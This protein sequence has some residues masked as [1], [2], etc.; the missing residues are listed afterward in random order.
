MT[1]VQMDSILQA[2]AQGGTNWAL[3]NDQ[4]NSQS[5][6]LTAAGRCVVGSSTTLLNFTGSLPQGGSLLGIAI[7]LWFQAGFL[8]EQSVSTFIE[9]SKQFLQA[10]PQEQCAI[11]C[12]EGIVAISIISYLPC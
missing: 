2:L 3:L 9:T 8:P 11:A 1:E 5:D 12:K 6:I 4:L 10:I 7:L